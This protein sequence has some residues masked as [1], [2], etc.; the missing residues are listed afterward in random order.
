MIRRPPRSTLFP[1]TTLFRS[2]LSTETRSCRPRPIA[3]RRDLG[4]L[5]SLG[6]LMAYR[7]SK[8]ERGALAGFAFEPDAPAVQL[9]ELLGQGEPQAGSFLLVGVVAADLA[10]LLEH[11]RLILG[12]DADARVVD[13]DDRG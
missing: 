12:R 5:A 8:G 3:R 4:S 11:G 9:D 10:E 2:R 13:R 7:N 6:A 1:Y